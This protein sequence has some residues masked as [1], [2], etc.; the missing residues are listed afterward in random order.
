MIHKCCSY[1]P[2][3]RYEM[4]QD[5]I[6]ILENLFYDENAMNAEMEIRQEIFA[7]RD[8]ENSNACVPPASPSHGSYVLNEDI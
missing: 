3:D 2:D 4:F 1:F 8:E 5:I 6:D 7:N